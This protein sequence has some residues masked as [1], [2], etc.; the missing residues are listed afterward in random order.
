M[1][2]E[3]KRRQRKMKWSKWLDSMAPPGIGTDWEIGR[4]LSG[5]TFALI[6][7]FQFFGNYNEAYSEFCDQMA[8]QAYIADFAEVLGGSLDWFYLYSVIVLCMV[9]RY[10][11]YYRKDSKSIYLM[12]RLPNRFELHKRAWALPLLGMLVTL[13]AAFVVLVVYFEIYMIVTPR[14]YIAPEQWQKIWR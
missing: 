8:K 12:K 3:E 10:Y 9:V 7:S 14:V 4:Y 13:L 5:L 2:R 6:M 11:L 1:N